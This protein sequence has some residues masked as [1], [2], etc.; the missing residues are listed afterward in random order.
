MGTRTAAAMFNLWVKIAWPPG[1]QESTNEKHLAK[2]RMGGVC[3]KE[4]LTYAS[5][6]PEELGQN[7]LKEGNGQSRGAE[8]RREF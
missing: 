8:N 1:W 3:L 6:T 4:C 5:P 7:H 2:E